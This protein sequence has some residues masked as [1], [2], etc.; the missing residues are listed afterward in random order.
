M[1][2]KKTIRYTGLGLL[3]LGLFILCYADAPSPTP[4]MSPSPV[5]S[6]SGKLS[7][8]DAAKLLVDFQR[9]QANELKALDHRQKMELKELKYSQS[10][11]QK[12]FE[13]R[14]KES[15]HVFF[16]EHSEGPKR[17]DYVKDFLERRTVM[18]SVMKEEKSKRA[19]EQDIYVSAVRDDQATKLKE[20]KEALAKS[21][22]PPESLWPRTG[23]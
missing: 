15:R 22:K 3:V 13:N 5:A 20:F 2:F 7:V 6:L 19:I 21:E 16:R 23:Q 12:E 10:A 17:R 1:N 8:S 18:I 9:A 11:R 14:E 4:S